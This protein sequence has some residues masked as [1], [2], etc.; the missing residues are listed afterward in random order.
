MIISNIQDR[1]INGQKE[2][3]ASVTFESSPQRTHKVF[4][5]RPDLGTALPAMGDP[6]LAGFLIP[7]LSLH[8]DLTI[9]GPVSKQLLSAAT[10]KLIPILLDWH[11]SFRKQRVRCNPISV[12][13]ESSSP[14]R[15]SCLFSCGL[16][17]WYS[18]VKNHSRISH[19]IHIHGFEIDL[20]NPARWDLLHH[21]VQQA[22]ESE[23]KEVI[24]IRTNLLELVL[25][26]VHTRLAMWGRP[27]PHFGVDAYFGSMLV[28]VGLALGGCL[29]EVMIPST[30]PSGHPPPQGSDPL[31]EPNWSTECVNFTL[32]GGEAGRIDK[33]QFLLTQA[34]EA[35]RR[36]CVCVDK[37]DKKG[38]Y[39]NCGHCVKCVRTLM[40]MRLCG[41][42]EISDSFHSPLNL[43]H[44]RRFQRSVKESIFWND[45]LEHAE[46]LDDRELIYTIR[47]ILGKKWH[48]QRLG[49]YTLEAI[50]WILRQYRLRKH[51]LQFLI[52]R[53]LSEK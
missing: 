8:E 16:D 26:E 34:P 47:I 2:L 10:E 35:L 25:S 33:I 7:C 43:G 48:F 23:G 3:S 39:L 4:F 15:T 36:L 31:M 42:L 46:K 18:L 9:E 28:S 49:I 30:K 52:R 51:R 44:V 6:Y 11:P 53:R 19:L 20:D 27:F 32:D 1:L 29:N 13:P 14:Q 40:E 22:A 24:P 12:S 41:A 17:S 21:F 38:K 37:S 50:K 5:R 45:V